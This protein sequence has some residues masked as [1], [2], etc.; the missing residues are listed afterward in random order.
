MPP[1]QRSHLRGGAGGSV[2]AGDAT[3]TGLG[4]AFGWAG[5]ACF[6]GAGAGGG[7][8][9]GAGFGG[10]FGAGAGVTG[11]GGGLGVTGSGG[12]TAAAGLAAPATA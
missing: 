5:W 4:T 3:G 6:A 10:A 9:A 1:T 12:G 8:D 7:T 11:T 2:D